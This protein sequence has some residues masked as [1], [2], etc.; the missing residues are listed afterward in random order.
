MKKN[1]KDNDELQLKIKKLE[2]ELRDLKN[3]LP[4][5]KTANFPA[6]FEG[7]FNQAQNTVKDYFSNLRWNPENGS[8]EIGDQR[9][10]LIRAKSISNNFHE[11]IKELYC[12]RSEEEVFE[13]ASSLLFDIGHLIGSE[14]AKKF[15]KKM[16]LEDPVSKLSA[17][18]VH[19]A[20]SGWAFV[21]ILPESNPIPD[22]NFFLKYNH[23]YSF[24][25]DSWLKSGKKSA[26][27]V[28]SMSAAYSSAWCSESYGIPLTAVEITC[29]AKGDE[30]CTFIMARPDKI[31][32]FL[33]KEIINQNLKYKPKVS[34][35][36]ERKQADEKLLRNE[37]LLRAA[38]KISKI[39]SWEFNLSNNELFWSEELYHIFG[40]DP[41]TK[42]DELYEVYLSRIAKKDLPELQYHIEQAIQKGKEYTFRH[43]IEL[44]D[45]RKK[46]IF[47]SCLPI[48]NSEGTTVKLVG[49]TQDI[50]EKTNTEKELNEF[51]RLS[52]DLLCIAN[53]N[54]Y[55]EKLS[56]GWIKKT[57]FSHKT[58]TSKPFVEFFHKEDVPKI[59]IE[60]EK[61]SKGA[62]AVNFENRF[63]CNDGK[64]IILKWN[65]SPDEL[66][67][68]IYCITRDITEE[69]KAEEKLN[70][71]LKEKE[72][73][74]KEVHHRVKNNLQIISSLLNLQTN[75]IEDDVTKSLYIESQNRIKSIASIH[76]LLYQSINIGKINF[77]HYLNKLCCDLCHSHFGNN[78]NINILIETEEEFGIDT[79]VPLGLLIN[80][81][82]S[83]S[84]KHGLK[85][86]E[87]E[88]I[89]IS[90]FKYESDKYELKISD[91]GTGFDNLKSMHT[92][93][94]LGLMLI[95]ELSSQLNGHIE[96]VASEIGT[97]YQLIFSEN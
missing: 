65:A 71:T 44:Q 16:K 1:L 46:W 4:A 38:Q 11:N 39:G 88:F 95:E 23:P 27:P 89:K 81:I 63:I 17:G 72:I 30:Q 78:L 25:A 7:I 76:E 59:L 50:T 60:L 68:L 40:I 13:I 87:N 19:F 2:E 48:I 3:Q 26:Y 52:R 49:Y 47:S 94:S 28:C 58:L 55:F 66:T 15:H 69:R 12:E 32:Y 74:L 92:K 18:P 85:N 6:E 96:K 21:D 73:L 67:G 84:L 61:I 90:I 82:V 43:G 29:K 8:I 5:I 83:N 70:S 20:Y 24:E 10:V 34:Y 54:G 37:Q 45:E 64:E 80:E 56:N 22:H 93:E 77:N 35:F 14:D 36:F 42:T 51:F 91:N 97:V 79:S 9:Y 62:F 75:Y 86:S 41:T 53:F 31:S 33:E 57:G